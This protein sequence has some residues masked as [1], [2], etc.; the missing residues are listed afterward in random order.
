MFSV[1]GAGKI[2]VSL[3]RAGRRLLASAKELKLTAG[4]QFTPTAHPP[5]RT[6]TTVSLKR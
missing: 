4:V 1:A 2:K 5:I 6:T 3:T